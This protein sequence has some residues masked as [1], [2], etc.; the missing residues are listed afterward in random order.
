[1]LSCR[2]RFVASSSDTKYLGK[3]KKFTQFLRFQRASTQAIAAQWHRLAQ[4]LIIRECL[5][6]T[7][8]EAF[9]EDLDYEVILGQILEHP[10]RHNADGDE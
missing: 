4:G 8:E 2:R 6:E 9:Q 5:S 1:M 7:L 3:W 10:D